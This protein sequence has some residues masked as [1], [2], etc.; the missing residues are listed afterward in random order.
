MITE[1]TA[2]ESNQQNNIT[3]IRNTRREYFLYF[4]IIGVNLLGGF[5]A[6][7]GNNNNNLSLGNNNNNNLPPVLS[8]GFKEGF[9]KRFNSSPRENLGG[10]DPNVIALVN[11][12]TGAN[13]RIDHIKREL[14]HIKLIE[15]REMEAENPNKQL[16]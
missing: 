1:A 13:L 11:V 2:R 12:L 10:L 5:E 8:P 15:F 3:S 6:F 16:K 7:E 4:G 14:N 9:G